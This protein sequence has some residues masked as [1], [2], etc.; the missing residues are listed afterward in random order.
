MT[1]E[2]TG[3]EIQQSGSSPA[4]RLPEVGLSHHRAPGTPFSSSAPLEHDALRSTQMA[5]PGVAHWLTLASELICE[6][7]VS[8]WLTPVSWAGYEGGGGNAPEALGTERGTCSAGARSLPDHGLRA[9]HT[10]SIRR[11][12]RAPLPLPNFGDVIYKVSVP[13]EHRLSRGRQ[14]ESLI[15]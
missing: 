14:T 8:V 1:A 2:S 13:V 3:F 9:G 10:H 11:C 4:S 5:P 6:P 12:C 15:L 7:R